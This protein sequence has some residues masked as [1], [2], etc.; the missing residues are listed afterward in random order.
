MHKDLYWLGSA[1]I[2][3]VAILY[4][5]FLPVDKSNVVV[6]QYDCRSLIGNWHPEVP[7]QVIEECK[8]RKLK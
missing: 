7:A 1:C 5:A 3:I 4:L 2:F 6:I 8:K